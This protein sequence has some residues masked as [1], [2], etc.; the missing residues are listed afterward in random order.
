MQHDASRVVQAAIQFGNTS[1]RSSLLKE[2]APAIPE[3]SK[4]QYAHFVVLKLINYC[5]GNDTVITKSKGKNKEKSIAQATEVEQQ[6]RIIIKAFKGHMP[7]LC[8][9]AVGARCV[10]LLFGSFPPKEFA[11]LRYE[12]YGPHLALFLSGT[13]T[14]TNASLM[15]LLKDHA[16]KREQVLAFVANV[17]S[18]GGDKG[19]YSFAYFQKLYWEYTQSLLLLPRDKDSTSM[20]AE[21]DDKI[22]QEGK[23]KI[24]KEISSTVSDHA[25]QMISSR[26]GTRVVCEGAA[27]GT[28]KDR[29]KVLKSLKGYTRSS[30]LHRDAYLL[31][32]RVL[33]VMDD[34]VT[35]QKMM[36]HEI[37]TRPEKE[38]E[39]D[40]AE[41]PLLELA[42]HDTGSKLFLRLLAPENSSY[43][44]P[45]ELDILAPATMKDADGNVFSTSKK[46][47]SARQNELLNYLKTSLETLATQHTAELMR[48][49]SGSKVLR[50]IL[51]SFPS[52]QLASAITAATHQSSSDD[53]EAD[54]KE[55]KKSVSVFEDPVAQIFIKNVILLEVVEANLAKN[56]SNKKINKWSQERVE[57]YKK[58][59]ISFAANLY[60]EYKGS[61]LDKVGF[62]NRGAFVLE[63]LCRVDSTGS[64]VKKELSK[65]SSKM[66][67][68]GKKQKGFECLTQILK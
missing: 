44:D 43:M 1:Q 32:L 56:E 15:V 16:D 39:V 24:Q 47:A 51:L 66:A 29:K 8:I 12:L 48:S 28:P 26:A 14:Y 20:N 63:A 38:M 35:V 45:L 59:G 41:S 11:S 34:T 7:K 49:K 4:I 46:E 58:S 9:H 3:L 52:E 61:L 68:L 53:D 37:I 50:E 21:D 31:I 62:C 64:K 30:L 25:I 27:Y 23:L 5:G 36:L 54:D 6:R 67:K 65:E 10:E 17:L 60:N 13:E 18:K 57:Q 42:L 40:D 19:L 33:D 2:L 55:G 22:L